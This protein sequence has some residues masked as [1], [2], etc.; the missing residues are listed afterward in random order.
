MSNTSCSVF[1]GSY[2]PFISM[3]RPI[4]LVRE[5]CV[6]MF[7]LGRVIKPSSVKKVRGS[8]VRQLMQKMHAF[9][10]VNVEIHLL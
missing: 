1:G 10:C 3:D 2:F 5:S 8:R 9:V 6:K 7:A 4:E